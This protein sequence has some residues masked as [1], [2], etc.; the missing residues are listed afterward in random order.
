MKAENFPLKRKLVDMNVDL[1]AK[2]NELTVAYAKLAKFQKKIE[3]DERIRKDKE[4][5]LAFEKPIEDNIGA[6]MELLKNQKEEVCHKERAVEAKRIAHLKQ[7][8]KEKE[9]K[10]KDHCIM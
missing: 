2:T 7:F 9:Q 6:R 3:E 1:Q 10:D 4:Q 8:I 5:K